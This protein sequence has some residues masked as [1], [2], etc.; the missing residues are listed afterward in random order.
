MICQDR[1]GTNVTKFGVFFSL[2]VLI[3]HRSYPYDPPAMAIAPSQ[4]TPMLFLLCFVLS[5][6]WQTEHFHLTA[7]K[8]QALGVSFRVVLCCV[9]REL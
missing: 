9:Y 2:T 1:L 7:S 8:T 3:A 6:S 4:T 5:L